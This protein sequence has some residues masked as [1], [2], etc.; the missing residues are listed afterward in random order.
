MH[1]LGTCRRIDATQA[2][3]LMKGA[4]ASGDQ[5]AWGIFSPATADPALFVA[6]PFMVT[7]GEVTPMPV[8]LASDLLEELRA[9]LPAGLTADPGCEVEGLLEVWG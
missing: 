1:D 4:A 3:R 6:R 2:D 8:Y 5:I 7:G 9:Q